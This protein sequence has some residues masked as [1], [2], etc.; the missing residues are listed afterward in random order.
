MLLQYGPPAQ[1]TLRRFMGEHLLVCE[2][3]YH[4]TRVFG[5]VGSNAWKL[6]QDRYSGL[7]ELC[8]RCLGPTLDGGQ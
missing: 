7:L 5:R 3:L 2:V 1:P 6:A 4:L 8:L